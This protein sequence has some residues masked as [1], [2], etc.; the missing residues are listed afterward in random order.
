MEGEPENP[1]FSLTGRVMENN[2]CQ[3]QES[4]RRIEGGVM[5][6]R[7]SQLRC[8]LLGSPLGT[9]EAAPFACI[10]HLLM[11]L[12]SI[13]RSPTKH[14]RRLHLVDAF[15]QSNMQFHQS[16]AG[17]TGVKRFVQGPS[18]EITAMVSELLNF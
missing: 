16:P 18:N 10:A 5:R 9:P 6:R 8:Q 1:A 17:A 3:L 11:I 12:P 2:Q 13:F 15:T 7:P 14:L 4:R